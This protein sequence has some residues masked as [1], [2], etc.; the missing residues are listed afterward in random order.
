MPPEDFLHRT[1]PSAL[2]GSFPLIQ[3]VCSTLAGFDFHHG[4][5]SQSAF[6]R[7]A[8]RHMTSPCLDLRL[9]FEVWLAQR[10]SQTRSI[11]NVERKRRKLSREVGPTRIV[12]NDPTAWSK[13]LD[14]KH[15]ALKGKRRRTV[16]DEPWVVAVLETIRDERSMGFSG[17][18]STLYAGDRIVAAHFGMKSRTVLHWWFPTYDPAFSKY[19]PGLILLLEL[20][21]YLDPSEIGLI[22]LGRGQERYKAEFANTGIAICEGSITKGINPLCLLRDV[23]ALAVRTADSM[24]PEKHASFFFRASNRVLRSGRL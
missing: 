13:F 16:L 21:R 18:L 6:E 7:A 8:L 20:A 23:R 19:S 2:L 4:L 9:G 15:E 11:T 17:V 14:W 24:L 1:Y 5:S 22:D 3:A 12:F 10:K